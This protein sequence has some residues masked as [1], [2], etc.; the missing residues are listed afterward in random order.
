MV[1]DL[2]FAT[3]AARRL[4]ISKSRFYDWLSLSD[5]GQ[6]SIRGRRMTIAYFQGGPKGQGPIRIA[7]KEV[8]RLVEAT[9]VRPASIRGPIERRRTYPGIT[10]EL[11]LPSNRGDKR[12]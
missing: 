5:L 10:V 1:E 12:R 8:E 6:F 3:E 4:G 7:A 9:R 2:L 11:G